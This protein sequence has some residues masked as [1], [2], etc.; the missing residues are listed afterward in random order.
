MNQLIIKITKPMK[1]SVFAFIIA[2][3]S[4]SSF[5][6]SPPIDSGPKL[7]S[8]LPEL[9]VLDQFGDK[10]KLSNIIRSKGAIIVLFR[11]ADWC[12]FC[13]RHLVELQSEAYKFRNK[14]YGVMGISYDTPKTLRKFSHKKKLSYTL[15]SDQNV[16]TFKAL[17]VVNTENKPGDRHYG[18][19]FP[20]VIVVDNMG[21]VVYTYF[22]EGYKKRVKFKKLLKDLDSI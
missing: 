5:A 1:L 10:Q 12:P 19:P 15:L 4:F 7:G 6:A 11:S 21:K 17:N 3:C 20:G 2:I 13:K 18:I 16:E 14:G 8:Q 9:T 22:F